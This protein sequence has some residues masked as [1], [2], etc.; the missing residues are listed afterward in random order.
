[1]Q[2][3]M[4]MSSSESLLIMKQGSGLGSRTGPTNDHD[5][6]LGPVATQ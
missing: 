5:I 4:Q 6:D 2:I 3:P 1:M